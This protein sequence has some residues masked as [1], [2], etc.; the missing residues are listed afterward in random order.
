M[1]RRL[2][3]LL[4]ALAVLTGCGTAPPA[5]VPPDSGVPAV[6]AHPV[7]EATARQAFGLLDRLDQAL[8]RRDCAAAAE[9]TT[10]AAKTLGG[11]ACEAT[12][13]GR[14][15]RDPRFYLPDAPDWF[16]AFAS[17]SY[18]VFLLED[19]RWLLGAGPIPAVG[20]PPE[21]TQ[22]A[23][24]DAAVLTE[25]A[26]VPQRHLTF[27]TDPAGVQGVRFPAGDPLVK[28]RSGVKDV[29]LIGGEPPAVA[30]SGDRVLVFDALRVRHGS[31]T[32]V[33]QVAS[34]VTAGN[35][36]AT[37]GLGRG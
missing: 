21:Y 22:G 8:A 18:Y 35:R 10:W 32:E 31:R 26:L 24:A 12:R 20:K 13:N 28:L 27:L 33:V 1:P 23:T 14:P 19:D 34:V 37:V 7:D 36:C 15:A 11:R 29:E 9:L 16:A 5:A 25:A 30:L 6:S 17:G 3:A 2:L 4:G